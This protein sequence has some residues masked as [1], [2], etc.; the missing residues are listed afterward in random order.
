MGVN[1]TGSARQ[2]D[3]KILP[4]CDARELFLRLGAR[5]HRE[6]GVLSRVIL[7]TALLVLGEDVQVRVL[8]GLPRAQRI[9]LCTK[10]FRAAD[11]FP[12]SLTRRQHPARAGARR[13]QA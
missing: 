1:L 2:L 6:R 11:S 5:R 3:G 10:Y 7:V 12:L 13:N 9:R 8:L 4:T